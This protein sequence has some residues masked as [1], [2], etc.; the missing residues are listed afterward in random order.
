[1]RVNPFLPAL[2]IISLVLP[3][4]VCEAANPIPGIGIVVKHCKCPPTWACCSSAA[5]RTTG[6]FF[7]PGSDPFDGFVG[8]EGRCSHDCGGCDNGCGGSGSSPDG[9]I[10]YAAEG[11]SGPFEMSMQSTV[12]YSIAPIQISINGVDSFFDVFVSI[13]GQGPLPD[14]PIPGMVTL[15]TGQTLDVGTSSQVYGSFLDL[16]CTITFADAVTGA[17]AGTAIEQDLHLALQDAGLPIKRLAD[18][19][20][21]GQ[22]VLGLDGANLVPF[23]YSSAGG[24]LTMK[25]YSLYQEAPVSVGART[26]GALKTLYR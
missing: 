23:T 5:A 10:D 6:G 2:I 25:M 9:R 18:G 15:P 24:E 12:L 3:L 7:G 17:A 22:I 4:G 1:M 26:W 8:L 16:H 21:G 13:S 11:A 14:D 19:T 20:A